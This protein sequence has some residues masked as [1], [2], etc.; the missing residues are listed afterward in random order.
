LLAPGDQLKAYEVVATLTEGGMATLVLARRRNPPE[1]GSALVALKVVHEH[2]SDDSG[3]IRLFLDEARVTARVKHPNVVVVEEVGIHQ[4]AYFLVM[5]YVHGVSLASLLRRLEIERRRMSPR[6]SVYLAAQLAEALH[7]AHEATDGRGRS[8]NVVHRDVSPQNVLI[9]HL[10]QVKLIDF[11]I[12]SSQTETG[13]LGKLCYMAPEQVTLTEV[14]RR[15][16]VYSLGIV[17]WET[18]TGRTL[19]R[20]QNFDEYRDPAIR[21]RIA[22]PSRYAAEV[23]PALDEVV[24]RALSPDPDARWESASAFRQALLQALPEAE[25]VDALAISALIHVFAEEELSRL[26]ARLPDDITAQLDARRA[27]SDKTLDSQTALALTV[28]QNDRGVSLSPAAPSATE[29]VRV[30]P[31]ALRFRSLPPSDRAPS[32]TLANRMRTWA[33]MAAVGVT[34]LL[35]GVAIGRSTHHPQPNAS[36]PAQPTGRQAIGA[37]A[38]PNAASRAHDAPASSAGDALAGGDQALPPA[39]KAGPDDE[40]DSPRRSKPRASWERRALNDEPR[41]KAKAKKRRRQR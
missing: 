8:L 2:L 41:S 16:D 35:G 40:L 25:G 11:G 23:T 34:C 39:D 28:E 4:G 37:I 20:S 3:M 32:A 7:A 18:L 15:A 31:I 5:E 27:L 19:F 22:A 33:P 9:S 17:L 6:L 21:I 30:E 13:V 1:S 12:A 36:A 10:G 26:R 14:D 29:E 38:P 24:L